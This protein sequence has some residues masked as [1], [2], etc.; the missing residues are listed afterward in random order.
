[1]RITEEAVKYFKSQFDD[2]VDGIIINI[3]KSCCVIGE[4][5]KIAFGKI[6]KNYVIIDTIKVQYDKYTEGFI[7][8]L[9]IDYKNNMIEFGDE[10]ND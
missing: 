7:N 1:M 2:E 3:N 8:R 6:D 4:D 5:I 9:V 10:G